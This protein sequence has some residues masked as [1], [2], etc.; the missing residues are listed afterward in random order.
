[1]LVLWHAIE[2]VELGILL[3]VIIVS[4]VAVRAQPIA[5]AVVGIGRRLDGSG[6]IAMAAGWQRRRLCMMLSM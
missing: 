5:R 2:L 6:T 1:M 4:S 3:V